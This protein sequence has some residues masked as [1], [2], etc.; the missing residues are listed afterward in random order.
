MGNQCC[1]EAK[2]DTEM[3]TFKMNKKSRAVRGN[4]RLS[5]NANS[6]PDD[7]KPDPLVATAVESMMKKSETVGKTLERLDG[8]IQEFKSNYKRSRRWRRIFLNL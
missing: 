8:D 1:S 6:N 2:E 3:S 4:S 7:H 5:R